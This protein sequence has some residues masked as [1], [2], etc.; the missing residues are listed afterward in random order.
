MFSFIRKGSSVLVTLMLGAISLV[1]VLS[2]GPGARGCQSVNP[3]QNI[4][5]YVIKINGNKI[6]IGEYQELRKQVYLEQQQLR[7]RLSEEE[8][9]KLVINR[10]V[11]QQLYLDYAKKLNLTVS[12]DERDDYITALPYFQVNGKFDYNTYKKVVQNYFNTT[13]LQYEQN[14][15]KAILVNKVTDILTSS[16]SVSDK[17]LWEMYKEANKSLDLSYIKFKP[18]DKDIEVNEE[19]IKNFVKNNEKEIKKYFD[20]HKDEFT[21]AKEVKASHILIKVDKNKKDEEA[22]KEIEKIAKEVKPENFTEMAK[23]YSEGPSKTNGGDLGYFTRN[24]MVKEFSDVA[25]SLKVNEISKPVKTKFGYH[26]IMVTGIKEAHSD[27][28]EDVKT[29]IAERLLKEKKKKEVLAK[30]KSSILENLKKAKNLK[31]LADLMPGYKIEKI[32]AVKY[33][34]Y[35]FIPSLNIAKNLLDDLFKKDV[36]AGTLLNKTY[37]INGSLVVV[38]ADK[39]NLDKSKFEE[40]KEKLRETALQYDKALF[41]AS[42]VDEKRKESKLIVHP[43]YLPKN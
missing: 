24:R 11:A 36:K 17:K 20:E 2:F 42:W 34:P 1:F 3:N 41:L 27:K 39:V 13:P 33:N 40:E 38:Q 43:N 22:K 14:I 32:E 35:G 29:K 23:K 26:L 30:L 19:D 9:N 21:H 12:D 18:S 6:G 31:E 10:L 37:D 25:F 7:K 4:A 8:L 15:K 16:I 28:Y 5:D